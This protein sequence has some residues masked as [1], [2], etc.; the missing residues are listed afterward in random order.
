M[1]FDIFNAIEAVVN[2]DLFTNQ[3]DWLKLQLGILKALNKIIN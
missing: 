2:S 3:Q 1:I